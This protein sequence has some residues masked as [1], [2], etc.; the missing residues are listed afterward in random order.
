MIRFRGL[1]KLLVAAYLCT[2]LGISGLYAGP[3]G[4]PLRVLTYN[5]HHAEGTDGVFDYQRLADLILDLEPDVVALQEVDRGTARA[6]GVDQIARLAELTGMK[7]AYGKAMDY[8]GGAYGNAVLSR[9]PLTETRV[10]PL[11]FEQ[12]R[13]PRAALEVL[14]QPPGESAPF[15][16]VSTHLCHLD[17]PSRLRQIE[18][19]ERVLDVDGS[20]PVILAGDF[21]SRPGSAPVRALL[22]AGWKDATE[23]QS[24]IDYVFV[25]ERDPWQVLE[26]QTV[27]DRIASDHRPVLAV[28]QPAAADR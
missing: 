28:L 8:S 4:P 15:R 22:E 17:E 14:V 27:N 23:A 18:E 1:L 13:E 26:V 16:F 2:G 20:A 9:F 12:G 6:K 21:N 5:I 11:P 10:H 3:E 7:Y 19:L 24:I 25:R